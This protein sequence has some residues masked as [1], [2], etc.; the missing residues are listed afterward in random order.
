MITASMRTASHCRFGTVLLTV[1]LLLSASCKK[2]EGASQPDHPRLT[3]NVVL[4]NVTF[5]SAALNRDMQYRVVSPSSLAPAQR[6]RAVYLL[7]GSG[8]GFRDWSN[9]SDVARYAESGLL[10]VM[11]EGGSSYYTNA[12]DPPQDRYE[13]YIVRDLISDVESKFPVATGRSNR[14]IVGVS[15]GGFGAVKLALRHPDLFIFAGG[16]SSA[17]DVPRRAFSIKR[18]EQSRH[19]SSIFGP[20]GS[21]ARRDNDPFVLVRTASPDVTPYFFLTCGEQEGLL[22]AN[23]EFATL[24]AARHFRFEFHTVPG[25][26]DW[27]QWNAWLPTLFRSLAEQMHPKN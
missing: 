14:A 12:V 21:P 15:M 17:I 24:L 23:R 5:R 27:N 4:R 10:L 18:L 25:G 19:Y 8:G 26:H 16:I 1:I 22:P 7:H 3:P 6:L 2:Q 20:S 9:D 13:D 11:P